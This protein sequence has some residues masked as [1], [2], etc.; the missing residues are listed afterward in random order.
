MGKRHHLFQEKPNIFTA[1]VMK[2]HFQCGF[3]ILSMT[4]VVR[5]NLYNTLAAAKTH[6]KTKEKRSTKWLVEMLI[7]KEH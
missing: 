6:N 2:N 3:F 4:L 1:L 5:V 7:K